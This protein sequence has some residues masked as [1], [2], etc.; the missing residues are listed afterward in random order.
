MSQPFEQ[1]KPRAPR[2]WPV[3]AVEAGGWAYAAQ[4]LHSLVQAGTEW[5]IPGSLLAAGLA[6]KNIIRGFDDRSKFKEEN[7]KRGRLKETAR[8][9][10]DARFATSGEIALANLFAPQGIFLGTYRTKRGKLRD[11]RYDG[12]CSV[13]VCGFPGSQK[14]LSIALPTILLD[15]G[16]SRIVN[17]PSG[18]LYALSRDWLIR[19][20]HIVKVISP[21]ASEVQSMLGIPVED[22]GFDFFADFDPEAAP[23]SIRS[24]IMR[25]SELL[26][27]GKPQGVADERSKFFRD[28]GRI[29]LECLTLIIAATG[30][31]PTLPM[32]RRLLMEGLAAMEQRFDAATRSDAFGG[33]LAELAASLLGTMQQAPEQF[34]GY[35]G[36]AQAAT[37]IFDHFGEMGEHAAGKTFDPYTLKDEQ[38]TTAFVI[39]PN[40]KSRTHSAGVNLTLSHIFETVASDP[41]RKRVTAIIDEA[42]SCGFLVNYLSALNEYRK[43]GLRILSLWQDLLGGQTESIYSRSGTKQIIA[44]GEVL[45]VCGAREPDTLDMLSKATGQVALEDLSLTDR[46]RLSDAVPDQTM[47]QSSKTRPLMYADEIRRIPFDQALI[48]A[49][50]LRPIIASK[51]PYWTRPD[52]RHMVGHNPYYKG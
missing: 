19:R 17:D 51:T 22:A 35:F 6:A 52:W 36:V 13:N 29:L 28:H 23:S 9:Q 31:K 32:L 46:S 3:S 10:A 33:V 25:R 43:Y 12:D 5:A 38:P 49:S 20:G 24:Q 8:K 40:E 27:P 47:G 1:S 42:A 37:T 26:I 11:L 30:K 15:I 34:A 48:L 7:R 2:P 14:S 18:E 4:Y 21:W 45:V 16:H 41:R 44:A 39:Y 50:N